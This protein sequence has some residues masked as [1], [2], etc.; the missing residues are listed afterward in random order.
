MDPEVDRA[1]ASRPAAL[2]RRRFLRG[3]AAAGVAAS[4]GGVAAFLAACSP[5]TSPSPSSSQGSAMPSS[6]SPPPA[7]ASADPSAVEPSPSAS[8]TATSSPPPALS[9]EQKI[10]GLMIVGFRGS[11][12]EQTPWIRTAVADR[13]LRGVILF[14]RDQPTG[15][16]RNVL[17][18]AQVRRLVADLRAAAAPRAIVASIDQEGGIVTRL[19]PTH[20]FPALASEAEIG[21]G[22]VATARRWASTMATTLAD[23]GIDLD[24]APVVDLNVNRHSPAI[25][26]LDRSFSADPDVVVRMSTIEIE[27]LRRVGVRSTLKHFPGIGSS[28]TNTDFGVAD[29][30]KTW[31]RTEL[32][33][34]RQLIAAGT[35]D[36]VMAG[37][38]VNGQLDPDR[39]ASLSK[40]IVTDLLRGELGWDGVVVTDDLQAAAITKRFGR[41][42]AV[43]LAL[44][45]GND[46]LLF[47][48]QQV[49]DKTIVERVVGVVAAAVASGRLPEGRIDE[50]WARV[51]RRFGATAP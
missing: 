32:E 46:L 33:P 15:A 14:D 2:T 22:T 3:A 31:S 43:L 39:P 44:E 28:T 48:N 18:A 19:S 17:S 40:A 23:A 45:A 50:A 20:G 25:G 16:Q 5:Q 9:L 26:G 27:A 11:R 47:A 34:F 1:A 6:G 37:H 35:A 24:Y 12:L 49:Y 13:G 8:A 38:V 10:A 4:L 21:G 7:S 29:V 51:E 36:L 41:D 42:E 30:T